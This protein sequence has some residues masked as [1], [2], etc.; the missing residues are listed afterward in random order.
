MLVVEDD[1]AIREL[2]ADRL[3]PYELTFSACQLDCFERL[4]AAEL[5]LVLLDLRLPRTPSDMAASNEV[6][7]D[8]LR[9]IRNRGLRKRGST[10]V[11]PVIVMTAYGSEAITAQVL[12][13]CGANDYIPKPFRQGD[14]LERKIER[15]LTGA[16]AL[17]PAANASASAV[18]IY[19]DPDARSLRIESIPY[20]EHYDLMKALIE[21]HA[22]DLGALR[23][24]DDYAA[25]PGRDLARILNIG[26]KALR[27]RVSRFRETIAN[28]LRK[29]LGR[30]VGPNDI[31][32][33][34]RRWKGYR[35]NPRTVR[36][37]R[38]DASSAR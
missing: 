7:L 34:Q 12:V 20:P 16:G 32:E 5:D 38:H 33:N 3:R 14:D 35:L 2:L 36:V 28:D 4:D 9:Q 13:E 31:I 26:E 11:L 10:M 6:G 30:A 29:Q 24:W 21:A 19:F 25:I 1:K 22:R 23:A 15:A 27:Q 8:I 18:C 17:V 37:F